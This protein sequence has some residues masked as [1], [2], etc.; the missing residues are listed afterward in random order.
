MEGMQAQAARTEMPPATRRSVRRGARAFALRNLFARPFAS[1]R[2]WPTP[3]SVSYVSV[4]PMQPSPNGSFGVLRLPRHSAA[5]CADRRP[6]PFH[7]FDASKRALMPR[8]PSVH[9]KYP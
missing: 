9:R 7:P 8:A 6:S 3:S 4:F 5:V 2:P 1:L